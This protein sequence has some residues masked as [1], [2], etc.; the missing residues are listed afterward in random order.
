MYRGEVARMS[1]LPLTPE[2]GDVYK[3]SG[4]TVFF[5]DGWNELASV[6]EE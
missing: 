2:I 4:K 1:N 6:E 3:V 5:N